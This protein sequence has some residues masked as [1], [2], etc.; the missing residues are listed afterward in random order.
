MS[1]DSRQH[2]GS[3]PSDEQLFAANRLPTL[4]TANAELSWLLSHGYAMTSSLK[5]VGDHHGLSKRQR[6][7]LSRV[8]CSD[9]SRDARQAKCLS[10]QQLKGQ[11]VIIDGFNLLITIE[12]AL[13]GGV[14]L[15][16]RDGCTRDLASVHGTYRSVIE[17]QKAI[18]LIGEVLETLQPQSV[19]WLLD[20]PVSNSGRLAQK[21]R[22]EAVE[23][24]WP[25]HVDVT[26]NPDTDISASEKIA[27]SSDSSILDNVSR[28]V[29]FT[30]YIIAE[31]LP[32]AWLVD[33]NS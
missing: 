7:A 22:A 23:Y 33:L 30:S 6:V 25:W 10:V 16:C 21:I 17:T 15:I 8:A 27:M 3:H 11:E 9:Q 1:P 4:R 32:Q 19:E 20:K 26:F 29:N 5:L 13:A 2:R 28:W 14:I 18:C 24:G 12:A 31:R